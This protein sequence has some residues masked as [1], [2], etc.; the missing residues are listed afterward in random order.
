MR[1]M[2]PGGSTVCWPGMSKTSIAAISSV[3]PSSH[4]S[5]L[6]SSK[7]S[8]VFMKQASSSVWPF[9]HNRYW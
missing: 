7:S 1:H 8:G 2:L 3:E 4:L 9:L 5:V 6:P